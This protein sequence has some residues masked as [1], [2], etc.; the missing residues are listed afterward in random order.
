[1]SPTWHSTKPRCLHNLAQIF[2]KISQNSILVC[3]SWQSILLSTPSSPQTAVCTPF[4]LRRSQG[5]Q[6]YCVFV[7]VG[8]PKSRVTSPFPS[9]QSF[10]PWCWL[11]HPREKNKNP[12]AILRVTSSIASSN[13]ASLVLGSFPHQL[14]LPPKWSLDRPLNL[15]KIQEDIRHGTPTHGSTIP[16]HNCPTHTFSHS[17]FYQVPRPT[18]GWKNL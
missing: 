16:W 11:P 5:A 15:K 8:L 6:P 12:R 17:S 14:L 9:S 13:M 1:M 7:L 3:E 18:A 4:H 10:I 2:W